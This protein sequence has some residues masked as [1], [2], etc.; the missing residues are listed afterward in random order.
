VRDPVYILGTHDYQFGR[1]ARFIHWKAS[2]RRRVLQEKVFEPAEQ[3]KVLIVVTVEDFVEAGGADAFERTL[4]AAA[5][6]AVLF[7]ERGIAIGFI[8]DAALTGKD[9]LYRSVRNVPG[10]LASILEMMAR[11]RF[12]K[13]NDIRD[14]LRR[15]KGLPFGVTCL[16]F[17]YRF[18]AVSR[19]VDQY[20]K[21][22]RIPV[23]HYTHEHRSAGDES[24][25]GFRPGAIRA[26]K[27]LFLEKKD[28]DAA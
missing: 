27:D 4:E 8:T 23:I 12:E 28:E 16:C 24:L 14:G 15:H 18:G 9:I 5:S 13:G 11:M 10:H 19:S 25:K 22:K 6:I 1:P 20:L 7:N 21:G 26:V 17:S 3:E 2:A